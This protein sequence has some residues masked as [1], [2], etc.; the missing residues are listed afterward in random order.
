M[1]WKGRDVISIRDFSKEDIE[2]VLSTPRG[3]K[4]R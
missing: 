2:V 3:W 4:R 1:E